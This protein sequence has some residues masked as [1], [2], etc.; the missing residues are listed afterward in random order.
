MHDNPEGTLVLG[1]ASII[2]AFILTPDEK[3]VV[4]ADRDEHVRVSWYPEGWDVEKYCMG[5]KKY[6]LF[7][8]C[9]WRGID[10]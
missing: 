2:T 8:F 3:L 7:N 9:I 1:H 4:S 10:N 5:H 6:V